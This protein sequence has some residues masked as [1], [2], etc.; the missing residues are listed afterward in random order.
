MEIFASLE[1]SSGFD[2]FD[3][4]I[5][6]L[7][8]AAVSVILKNFGFKGA[9]LICALA[10]IC[11]AIPMLERLSALKSFGTDLVYPEAQRYVKAAVKVVGIGYLSGISADVCKEIGESGIAKC[12]SVVC[13]IELI[14]LSVPFIEEILQFATSLCSE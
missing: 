4:C 11:V 6:M 1:I 14:L 10:L 5:Y 12:I 2:F 3:F 7:L 13:K 9:P 8:V